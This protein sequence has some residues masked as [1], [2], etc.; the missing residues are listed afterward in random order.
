ML[1]MFQIQEKTC[2][3]LVYTYI[4]KSVRSRQKLKA[5]GYLSDQK[6]I[7]PKV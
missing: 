2:K 7:K 1:D 4:V 3:D 6:R 5:F